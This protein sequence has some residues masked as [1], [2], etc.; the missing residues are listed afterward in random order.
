M[1][2]K[3]EET[4][5]RV[6]RLLRLATG[7]S[8]VHL[9]AFKRELDELGVVLKVKKGLP[10]RLVHFVKQKDFHWFPYSGEKA[11]AQ[12][13]MLDAGFTAYESLI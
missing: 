7:K 4:R 9:E 11:D 1:S 2:S 5:E 13:E 10:M 8:G 3:Q 6:D 12:Q